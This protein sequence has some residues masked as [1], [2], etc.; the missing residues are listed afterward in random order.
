MNAARNEGD[1]ASEAFVESHASRAEANPAY[2]VTAGEAQLA[3]SLGVDPA[4]YT[5]A[6]L[7]AMLPGIDD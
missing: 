2:V 4:E 6:D 3:A 1:D 7:S 5:L